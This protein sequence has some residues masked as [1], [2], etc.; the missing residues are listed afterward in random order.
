M[1]RIG[2][3]GDIEKEAYAEWPVFEQVRDTDIFKETFRDIFG[4]DFKPY[5]APEFDH[6]RAFEFIKRKKLEKEAS[7]AEEAG[8][9]H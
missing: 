3:D 6:E 2:R 4:E 8:T 1:K 5:Q 7:S 9:V